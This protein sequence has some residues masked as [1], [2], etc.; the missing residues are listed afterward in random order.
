MKENNLKLDELCVKKQNEIND[1]KQTL[2]NESN[3]HEEEIA[4]LKSMIALKNSKIEE[5]ELTNNQ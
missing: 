2:Q 1:L 5:L 3:K 4:N